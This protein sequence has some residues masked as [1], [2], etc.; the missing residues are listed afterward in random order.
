T[1]ILLVN[2]VRGVHSL[3]DLTP[4]GVL[5][6][7][8]IDGLDG[9]SSLIQFDARLRRL[10]FVNESLTRPP[11]VYLSGDGGPQ[12][13]TSLNDGIAQRVRHHARE[14]SWRSTDGVTVSG[15]LLEP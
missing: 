9:S 13:V 8:S 6:S 2:T 12:R 3:F 11:E 5:P 10:A 1:R 15:W 4:A 7:Q 14:V